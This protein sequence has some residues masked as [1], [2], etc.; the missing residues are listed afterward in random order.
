MEIF[1]ASGRPF[2]RSTST[3][4]RAQ[5]NIG[6]LGSDLLMYFLNEF[7][8]ALRSLSFQ[9]WSGRCASLIHTRTDEWI[10]FSGSKDKSHFLRYIHLGPV[11]YGPFLNIKSRPS[12]F[13]NKK[14]K[15][16]RQHKFC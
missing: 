9:Q 4:I 1:I 7:L 10:S 13:S 12:L 14:M 5:E 15:N 3:K 11:K 6:G 8:I 2:S 16:P